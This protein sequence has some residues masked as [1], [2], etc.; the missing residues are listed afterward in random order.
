MRDEETD[1]EE[2]TAYRLLPDVI[3]VEA[4]R[5]CLDILGRNPVRGYPTGETSFHEAD[6]S[7]V[8]ADA[9][10]WSER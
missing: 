3:G 10:P 2:G 1:E 5:E 8:A 9:E 7:G 4:F 6:V